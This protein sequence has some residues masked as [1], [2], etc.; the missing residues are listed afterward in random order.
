MVHNAKQMVH[1]ITCQ[2]FLRVPELFQAAS[3]DDFPD[4]SE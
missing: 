2:V 1:P 3:K 4:G